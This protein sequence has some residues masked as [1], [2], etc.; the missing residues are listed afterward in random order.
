VGEEGLDIPNVYQV[1]FYE[2]ASDHRRRTQRMGRTGRHDYGYVYIFITSGT[3]EV[4]AHWKAERGHQKT[5]DWIAEHQKRHPYKKLAIEQASRLAAA[6][7][8]LREA[9]GW[10]RANATQMSRGRRILIDFSE[11]AGDFNDEQIREILFTMQSL[12]QDEKM[13]IYQ[14]DE[15]HPLGSFLRELKSERLILT[16]RDFNFVFKHWG[17]DFRGHVVEL[18]S[19]A[20]TLTLRAKPKLG[21]YVLAYGEND[22]GALGQL[23]SDLKHGKLRQQIDDESVVHFLPSYYTQSELGYL[24]IS[25]P[26]ILYDW[27]QLYEANLYFSRSA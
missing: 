6:R 17:A 18:R 25:T 20:E 3:S 4:R 10:T 2:P 7:S 9:V 1:I 27:K 16:N 11:L 22:S 12:D 23:L 15:L 8:E 14:C 24:Y 26:E 5:Q 19:A 21:Y 13:I